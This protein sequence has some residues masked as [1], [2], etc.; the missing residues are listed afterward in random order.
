M[1]ACQ[2]CVLTRCVISAML[3]ISRHKHV[4]IVGSQTLCICLDTHCLSASVS[5]FKTRQDFYRCGYI[6]DITA[7]HHINHLR[8]PYRAYVSSPSP[9]VT[10]CVYAL[11]CFII[12]ISLVATCFIVTN[13]TQVY[14]VEDWKS[15]LER[16]AKAY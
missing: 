16:N 1:S 12:F 14:E 3:N 6:A 5:P 2:A 13:T 15:R 10:R 9:N 8:V 7:T 4:L 11:K